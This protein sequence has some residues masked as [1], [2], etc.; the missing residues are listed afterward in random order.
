MNMPPD[1]VGIKLQSAKDTA[2]AVTFA[3]LLKHHPNREEVLATLREAHVAVPPAISHGVP[4]DLA[5]QIKQVF[6]DQVGMMRE[7]ERGL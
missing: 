6:Q 3:A 7:L 1:I 5:A 2:I 4:P